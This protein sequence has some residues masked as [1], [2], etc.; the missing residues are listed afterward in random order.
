MSK[1]SSAAEKKAK[2]EALRQAL[3][4][5]LDMLKTKYDEQIALNLTQTQSLADRETLIQ[6]LR[7][8]ANANPTPQNLSANL[9]RAVA[10]DENTL[11]SAIENLNGTLTARFNHELSI[12][13]GL[14]FTCTFP[15]H[16]NHV[17]KPQRKTRSP[18]KCECD[19]SRH[20]QN[21]NPPSSPRLGIFQHPL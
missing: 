19:T 1:Q 12:S 11:T 20:Y 17:D 10:I 6:E 4:Q 13:I 8:T 21:Y 9:Q 14:R 5:E 16:G 2:N 3:R 7:T 18:F 15:R